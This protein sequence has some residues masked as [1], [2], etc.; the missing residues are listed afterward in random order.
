MLAFIFVGDLIDT[1][2]QENNMQFQ[3]NLKSHW[4]LLATLS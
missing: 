1:S 3:V 4:W 2:T